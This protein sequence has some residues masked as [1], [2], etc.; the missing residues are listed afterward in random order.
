MARPSEFRL[1]RRRSSRGGAPEW[2]AA[3]RASQIEAAGYLGK[4][5]DLED[6]LSLVRDH[7]A[8]GRR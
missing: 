1:V 2:H 4:P 5:A 6:L 8:N 3:Q 7:V